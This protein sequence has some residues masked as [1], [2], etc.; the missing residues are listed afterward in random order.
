MLVLEVNLLV[1][2]EATSAR[3]YDVSSKMQMQ[4]GHSTTCPRPMDTVAQMGAPPAKMKL[5]VI[6]YAM[7]AKTLLNPDPASRMVGMPFATP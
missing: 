5:K 7:M 6:P 2:C 1:R 3:R 4:K